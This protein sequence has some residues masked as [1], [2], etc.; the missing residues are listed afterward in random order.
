MRYLLFV[1]LFQLS[2]SIHAQSFEDGAV[3]FNSNQFDDAITILSKVLEQP[4]NVPK[5]QRAD[6][7]Y[8]LGKSKLN[9][10]S[11]AM[12]M[13]SRSAYEKFEGYDLDAYD[14]FIQALEESPNNKLKGQIEKDLIALGQVLFNSGN[15]MYLQ[16]KP[17]LAVDYYSKAMGVAKNYG[18]TDDYLLY[19]MRGQCLVSLGDSTKAYEDFS[20]AIERYTSNKPEIPDANIGYA[21]MTLAYIEVYNKKNSSKALNFLE[22][23]Q[24]MLETEKARLAEL[25]DNSSQLNTS[26]LAQQQTLF[27]DVDNA[28]SRFELNIY[29]NSPDKREE[30]I[31]KFKKALEV[32]PNDPNIWLA[33]G[34]LIESNDIEEAY[35]AYKKSATLDPSNTS[36][37]FNAGANRVNKGTEYARKANEE[38]D[39]QKSRKWQEKVD[40]QFKLALPHLEKAHEL[41]PENVY[42]IDALLQVTIQ[43]DM[44]EDYK[45]YKEKQQQLRGY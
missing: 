11:R 7:W 12:S 36:A 15:S 16:S 38:F 9:L 39:L 8:Y 23:G 13:Q 43:L 1:L 25:I 42:I 20:T 31:L 33:Y 27:A 45:A 17:K 19:N 21:F 41:D 32:D 14:H 22:K 40:E 24:Q 4:N 29:L 35:S 37:H 34:T 26:D 30:A 2:N 18:M 6:A 3:A 28:L 5:K 44:M 10:M